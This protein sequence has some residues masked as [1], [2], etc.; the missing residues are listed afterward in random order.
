MLRN[1]DLFF[2]GCFDKELESKTGTEAWGSVEMKCL[3]WVTKDK[4]CLVSDFTKG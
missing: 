2:R 4:L 3:S 1:S